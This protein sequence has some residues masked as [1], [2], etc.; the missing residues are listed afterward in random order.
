MPAQPRIPAGGKVLFDVIRGETI[1]S[2][3]HWLR[4]KPTCFFVCQVSTIGASLDTNSPSGSSYGEQRCTLAQRWEEWSPVFWDSDSR[5]R[6]FN[7]YHWTWTRVLG[8]RLR[9]SLLCGEMPGLRISLRFTLGCVRCEARVSF[10]FFFKR[11]NTQ[12]R[13]HSLCAFPIST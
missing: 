10:S 8:L 11:K 1:Q 4:R 2:A 3:V 13:F 5:N 12:P 9:D 7:S 6:D